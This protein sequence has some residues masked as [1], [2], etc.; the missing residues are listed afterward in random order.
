[1]GG[2]PRSCPPG[3]NGRLSLPRTSGVG[4]VRCQRTDLKPDGRPGRISRWN[5]STEGE[6]VWIHALTIIGAVMEHGEEPATD[7]VLAVKARDGDQDAFA[8]LVRRYQQG[9]VNLAYRLVGNWEEALDLSQEIFLRVYQN[10]D[11][12]DA[13][14]PF[15]PWLYRIATNYC[16][17]HLRQR[18]RR[19]RAYVTTEWT[20]QAPVV[21]GRIDLEEHVLQGEIRQAVEEVIA[22]LPDRYRATVVLRYLEGLSY[23]EIAEALDMPLGTVKTHLYRAREQ[24]RAALKAKGVTP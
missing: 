8:E 5:T 7:E 10:L 4:I 15:K 21:D 13:Q 3:G 2:D 20:E 19:R 16:Y 23:Q 14:R 6:L 18:G 22:S 9:V 11:R 17:D 1:M 12:Y 24:M